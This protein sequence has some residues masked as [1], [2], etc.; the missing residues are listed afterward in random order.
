MNIPFLDLKSP[1][2]ELKAELD[3]AYKRFM[4]SGWITG[5]SLSRANI[6]L[7][8]L[9]LSSVIIVFAAQYVL[10]D[11]WHMIFGGTVTLAVGYY[12]IKC[13]F[14]M[15]DTDGTTPIISKIKTVFGYTTRR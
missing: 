13:L 2:Q 10:A 15:L 6:R 3:V 8:L 14:E 1:Y 9:T 7:G 11:F 12:S 5:F 4:E